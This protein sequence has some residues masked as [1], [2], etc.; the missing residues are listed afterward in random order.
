MEYKKR[1]MIK[2]PKVSPYIAPGLIAGFLY[3]GNKYSQDFIA[4][5]VSD[6]FNID[7]S[8]LFDKVRYREVVEARQIAMYLTNKLT[9]L[10][11]KSIGEFYGGRDHTTVIHSTRTVKN[12]MQTDHL[13]R[14]NV[15]A[16]AKIITG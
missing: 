13:Y 4:R 14:G 7:T 6:Y 5:S 9:N 1:S 15:E 3:S 10:S 12:L 16:L 11:L 8:R 2:Q